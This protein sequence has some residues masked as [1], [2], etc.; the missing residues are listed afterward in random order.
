LALLLSER[1]AAAS[2]AG[3]SPTAVPAAGAAG[4]GESEGVRRRARSLPVVATSLVGRDQDIARVSEL[5]A[6]P[7]VRLVTL[8]GPGGI[9]KT[10]LAGAVGERIEDRYPQGVVF[11]PL[12]SITEPELVLPRVATALGVAVEGTQSALDAVVEQLGDTPTLLVLDNLEQVVAVAPRLDELL[13]QCPGLTLLATSRTVL[14]L[15]A[16]RE[17]SRRG[18]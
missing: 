14:R 11:V 6:S 3:A 13:A 18:R 2:A 9:G 7:G 17:W 1:F 5:L 16:E 4:P 10:R 15:R 12:A 8:T